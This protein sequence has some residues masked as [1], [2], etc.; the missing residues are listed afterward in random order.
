M[1]Q[2]AYFM[3]SGADVPFSLS[4][5]F[6]VVVTVTPLAVVTVYKDGTSATSSSLVLPA[7]VVREHHWLGRSAHNTDGYF[8]GTIAYLRVWNGIVLS[9]ADVS[10]LYALREYCSAGSYGTGGSCASCPAGSYSGFGFA[11]CTVCGV[12]TVSGP[13]SYQC[14]AECPAGTYL[15]FGSSSCPSCAA[16]LYSAALS[17]LSSITCS[18]CAAGTYS[19]T[20][21]A[22]ACNVCAAGTYQTSTGSSG[23]SNCAGGTYSSRT[24]SPYASTC[25][26]CAAGSDSVAGAT[27]CSAMY[28]KSGSG[29]WA[30]CLSNCA[31]SGT[32]LAN[33]YTGVEN[34]AA[35][36]F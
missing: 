35:L 34:S 26:A 7:T 8:K 3:A 18:S 29:N 24:G 31:G 17:A 25:L 28:S 20:P 10:K 36:R 23:C 14:V 22:T 1:L 6:H 19:S 15:A 2:L 16:G 13:G 5:W 4:T 32:T 9:A 30:T 12:G 21:G 27:S 11:S 33:I